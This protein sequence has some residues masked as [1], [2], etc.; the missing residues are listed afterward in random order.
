M[1]GYLFYI[2]DRKRTT[3]PYI[4][5]PEANDDWFRLRREAAL[6]PGAIVRL[7]EAAQERYGFHD[8]KL[9]GGVLSGKKKSR[10]HPL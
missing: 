2:G 5:E 7:A 9:K 1:L 3:L 10:R 8:F 6:T 4:S